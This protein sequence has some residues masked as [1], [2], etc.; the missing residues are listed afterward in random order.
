MLCRRWNSAFSF[1]WQ[2]YNFYIYV[3]YNTVLQTVLRSPL[4]SETGSQS[5]VYGIVRR[6]EPWSTRQR[7]ASP[8]VI[9]MC[10]ADCY[11]EA[12]MALSSHRGGRV[13]G[14]SPRSSV[15]IVM[16]TQIACEK[17][18]CSCMD[19]VSGVDLPEATVLD[20]VVGSFDPCP[21]VVR[22]TLAPSRPA[23]QRHQS[24]GL[25]RM[26]YGNIMVRTGKYIIYY[27]NKTVATARSDARPWPPAI[28]S[29]RTTGV[30]TLSYRGLTPVNWLLHKLVKQFRED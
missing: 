7:A 19:A 29:W 14:L 27:S 8:S 9:A 18:R 28:Q 13:P 26:F 5:I 11:Y 15:V 3:F 4:R 1:T 12:P 16:R 2:Y 30:F 21:A 10:R 17:Y 25:R 6:N 22:F 24:S 20:C 23:P